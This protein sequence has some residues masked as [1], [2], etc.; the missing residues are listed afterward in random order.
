MSSRIGRRP[1]P[2]RLNITLPREDND[3]LE[4]IARETGCSRTDV[5]R[6]AIDTHRRMDRWTRRGYSVF[7]CKDDK[8][9]VLLLEA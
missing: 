4:R 9:Q 6:E 2:S 5:L 3:Y 1:A 7:A 8:P